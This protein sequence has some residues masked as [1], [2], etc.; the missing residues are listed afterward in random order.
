MA[1]E[2]SSTTK[3]SELKINIVDTYETFN[4]MEKDPNQL[5]FIEHEEPIGT[6]SAKNLIIT[7]TDP[8]FGIQFLRTGTSISNAPNYIQF[9]ES[10][11]LNFIGQDTLGNAGSM[12][13]LESD[14]TNP[15][16]FPGTTDTV[17]LGTTSLKWNNVYTKTVTLSQDPTNNLEAATKQYV[18]NAFAVND[19]MLFKGVVNANGNLPATHKQGWTYRVATAG[20]YAGKKCEVGD[21]IICVTDGTVANNDDW[22]VIQN[23]VDGAVYRGTNAFAD[24]DIIIADSTNGKVKSSGKTITT[25]AP[26]SSSADT[27]VPTSKAVWNA[28]SG[29]SGY[30]KTGTVTSVRVQAT[31]PVVSSSSAASSSTLN[32]TISLADGYGDTKNPY[33][34]K[35]ANYILAGPSSGNAAVPAFRQLVAADIPSLTKSK[36]SDFP[37]KVSAFTNDSGYLTSHQDISGK[38]DKSATVST[39]SWDSANKKITKTINGSS[40]DVVQFATGDNITLTGDSEKL[41]IAAT[42]TDTKVTS[43]G[44]HYSPSADTSAE[45]TATVSGTASSY[46]LNSEYTVLTGVKAQRD[47]KGHVTGLTYTAQKI[48]DTNTDTKVTQA[49][50]TTN[51]SYPLLLSATAGV[52]S[53]GTRGST[54]SILNNSFYANPNTGT[55]STKNLIITDTSSTARIEFSRTG[56]ANAPNYIQFPANSRLNFVG[57]PTRGTAVS[58]MILDSTEGNL[59]IFP[60][61]TDQV[62]LGTTSNKWNNVYAKTVTL[63]QDPVSDLEAATKRYVDNNAGSAAFEIPISYG[64]GRYY[65][66]SSIKGSTVLD[67]IDNCYLNI[68][69]YGKVNID[70]YLIDVASGQMLVT[71]FAKA[72]ENIDSD[73]QEYT[74]FKINAVGSSTTQT[75]T[76]E[77]LENYVPTTNNYIEPYN[78]STLT[79]NAI[80]VGAGNKTLKSSN[81]SITGTTISSSNNTYLESSNTTVVYGPNIVKLNTDIDNQKILLNNSGTTISDNTA[82]SLSTSQTA[83]QSINLTSKSININAD[84]IKFPGDYYC[85]SNCFYKSG[86]FIIEA[87]GQRDAMLALKAGSPDNRSYI[88]ISD[89]QSGIVIST[90]DSECDITIQ[91]YDKININGKMILTENINYGS[92]L[93]NSGTTGQ[94]FF[95]FV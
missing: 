34:T 45:L 56:G 50:S 21:I 68:D 94:I 20:T 11:R 12:M 74:I 81:L 6:F 42:N 41:T 26:S 66:N 48:K 23:N 57:G 64:S 2:L 84:S 63:S 55:L 17:N 73:E 29:A 28:I 18:D 43:V 13:I 35:T 9:P 19:A 24:T 52:S 60:G 80:I 7:N 70:N 51:N 93:P 14:P 5:Y 83:N 85:Y 36:I 72:Y 59:S 88:D 25:T 67:H 16:I 32:T 90:I 30:G 3:L 49:Y 92:S 53:T 69:G 79:N 37:T 39:V 1:L 65:V 33:G 47:A 58:M 89:Q 95:K 38:A 40:T 62:N 31:S 86:E 61:T 78:N 22:A 27:T 71:I 44:N 10:S 15:S 87:D 82:I 4:T 54:T 8:D 75:P 77:Y 91:S 46:T 76:V